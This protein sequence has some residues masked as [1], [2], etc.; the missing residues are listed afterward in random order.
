VKIL[1][2]FREKT[3]NY[4][5]TNAKAARKKKRPRNRPR[6]KKNKPV[7]PWA[8]HPGPAGK[9]KNVDGRFWKKKNPKKTEGTL[10]RGVPTTLNR[11]NET[12]PGKKGGTQA[13]NQQ[14]VGGL[15][16]AAERPGLKGQK[17]LESEDGRGKKAAL[18]EKSREKKHKPKKQDRWAIGDEPPYP[19]S[20]ALEKKIVG[21]YTKENLRKRVKVK[22]GAPPPPRAKAGYAKGEEV[23]KFQGEETSLLPPFK[24]PTSKPKKPEKINRSGGHRGPR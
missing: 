16:V 10:T 3:G 13:R 12:G 23:R 8:V 14:K 5:R 4:P 7:W 2:Q 17:G 24:P 6:G 11:N 21:V 15:S 22:L 1:C 9:Q 20:K 18:G 19:P